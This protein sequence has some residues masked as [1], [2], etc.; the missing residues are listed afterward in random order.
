[1]AN[2]YGTVSVTNLAVRELSG[3]GWGVKRKEIPLLIEIAASSPHST[4]SGG[5]SNNW[6][7]W[8]GCGQ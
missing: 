6:S 1:M 2:T 4:P 3:W 5:K 7:L 8:V